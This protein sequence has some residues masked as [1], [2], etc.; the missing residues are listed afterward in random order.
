MANTA[1]IPGL[2]GPIFLSVSKQIFSQISNRMSSCVRC[3]REN[4]LRGEELGAGT[5]RGNG[6]S[7]DSVAGRTLW[8]PEVIQ[9]RWDVGGCTP[10]VPCCLCTWHGHWLGPFQRGDCRWDGAG[11]AASF[12]SSRRRRLAGGEAQLFAPSAL[13]GEEE[14]AA[15]VA[16]D[17]LCVCSDSPWAKSKGRLG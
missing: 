9:E 14:G 12:L 16:T 3:Y 6:E 15:G 11:P 13:G 7:K 1:K 5:A 17:T 4:K 2:A 8:A 10:P